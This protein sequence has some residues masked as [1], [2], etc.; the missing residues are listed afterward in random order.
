MGKLKTAFHTYASVASLAILAK[1]GEPANQLLDAYVSGSDTSYTYKLADGYLDDGTLPD[2]GY[3]ADGVT[4]DV[5]PNY[6]VPYVQVAS[7]TTG[8]TYLNS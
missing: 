7:L 6:S 4:L 1:S 5:N 3:L 2:F 8:G